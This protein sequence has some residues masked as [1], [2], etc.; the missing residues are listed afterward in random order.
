MINKQQN[1]INLLHKMYEN[2]PYCSPVDYFNQSINEL[3][4][5]EIAENLA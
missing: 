4:E 2:Y 3:Q 1:M 5:Y